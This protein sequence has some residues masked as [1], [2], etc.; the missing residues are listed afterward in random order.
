LYI[1]TNLGFFSF[2]NTGCRCESIL[3]QRNYLLD[4]STWLVILPRILDFSHFSL[5]NELRMFSTYLTIQYNCWMQCYAEFHCQMTS[6]DDRELECL[7]R[8][9]SVNRCSISIIAKKYALLVSAIS[10]RCYLFVVSAGRYR[11]EMHS[12]NYFCTAALTSDWMY[13][14]QFKFPLHLNFTRFVDDVCWLFLWNSISNIK[15]SCF[16]DSRVHF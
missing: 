16:I 3:N 9:W 12:Q 11:V 10:H 13:L 1:C 7:D 5:E 8:I 4:L 2:T 14:L 15:L 6:D